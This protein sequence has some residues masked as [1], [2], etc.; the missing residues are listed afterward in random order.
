M[1]R[2][3]LKIESGGYS[4]SVACAPL[5]PQFSELLLSC[6][7]SRPSHKHPETTAAMWTIEGLYLCL[8][9]FAPS[10]AYWN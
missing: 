5:V 2:E 10:F 8:L 9:V 4:G 7:S 3:S 1:L 6:Y